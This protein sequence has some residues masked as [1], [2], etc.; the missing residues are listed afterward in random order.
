MATIT[1]NKKA[2]SEALSNTGFAALTRGQDPSTYVL[3]MDLVSWKVALEYANKASVDGD[4]RLARES[5]ARLNFTAQR[6]WST[7]GILA[8]KPVLSEDAVY[9][10]IRSDL[11]DHTI[12]EE[13]Q[14]EGAVRKC[15][16]LDNRKNSYQALL[17]KLT[18]AFKMAE[19]NEQ[20]VVLETSAYGK[21][22]N[23]NWFDSAQVLLLK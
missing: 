2:A 9:F 12:S 11:Y 21:W 17:Q 6:N 14:V 23:S 16:L 22:S 5:S 20:T 18:L 15:K 3:P 7:F 10:E 4:E 1:K 8:E 13:E 19:A